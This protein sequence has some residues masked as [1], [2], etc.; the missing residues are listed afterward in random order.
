MNQAGLDMNQADFDILSLGHLCI[1]LNIVD[2]MKT[3]H[4][5]CMH[6]EDQWKKTKWFWRGSLITCQTWSEIFVK[7]YAI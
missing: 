2:G 1:H 6:S 4:V 5:N 7:G 3:W